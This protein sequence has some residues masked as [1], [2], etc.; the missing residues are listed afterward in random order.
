MAVGDYVIACLGM[1]GKATRKTQVR[2]PQEPDTMQHTSGQK[3]VFTKSHDSNNVSIAKEARPS[4]DS[5]FSLLASSTRTRPTQC[6]ASGG[7]I[8]RL[9]LEINV[10]PAL[11]VDAKRD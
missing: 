1:H 3:L 7:G 9:E 10:A 11:Q 2:S 4:L 5:G 6:S 8:V